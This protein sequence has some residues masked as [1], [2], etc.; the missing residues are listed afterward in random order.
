MLPLQE[1]PVGGSPG[2]AEGPPTQKRW[3]QEASLGPGCEV[4][5]GA[6]SLGV[7]RWEL[8]PSSR[9]QRGHRE[10]R[11][12]LE[13][14]ARGM[15]DSR[16]E[17]MQER[18]QEHPRSASPLPWQSGASESSGHA[19]RRSDSRSRW[20]VPLWERGA[21]NKGGSFNCKFPGESMTFKLKWGSSEKLP[22]R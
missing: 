7:R 13:Q 15:H 8:P 10:Q 5:W 4:R 6:G 17:E 16:V 14:R 11:R 1:R 20:E 21:Q 9:R 19:G 12:C 22:S 2:A 3:G 18:G